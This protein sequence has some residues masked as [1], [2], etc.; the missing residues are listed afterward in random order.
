MF[1]AIDLLLIGTSRMAVLEV[2]VR[3]CHKAT[4]KKL[5]KKCWML[6]FLPSI[7]RQDAQFLQI[8]QKIWISVHVF[9]SVTL[10]EIT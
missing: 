7:V 10:T 1:H 4:S 3:I 9:G 5:C 6:A 2:E 8:L